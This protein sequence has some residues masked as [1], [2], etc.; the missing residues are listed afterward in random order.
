MEP[1]RFDGR[2]AI[3]TGAGRG[4]GRAHAKLLAERGALVVVNDLGGAPSGDGHDVAPAESV[5]AEV[6]AAGGEAVADASDVSTVDGAAALVARAID[7]YGRV[8]IVVNN[9]GISVSDEFPAAD[10]DHMRRYFDVHVGGTFNVT[11]EA[12]P[13]MVRAGYGRIVNTAS[14]GIYGAVTLIA[15]GT[16]KA[17]IFS[18]TRSLAL[19]GRELGIKVNTVAPVA[20]TRLTGASAEEG[21]EPSDAGL[22]SPRLVSP[23]VAVLCHE[24]C[25]VT[26]E[27]FISGGR[28]QA[29][30]YVAETEGY[31]HPGLDVTPEAVAAN[32]AEVMDPADHMV[33]PDTISWV[34]MH[35]AIVAERS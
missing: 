27:A 11:R 25:P 2:V 1:L 32:W 29:L 15:Y 22:G 3:V 8:D 34:G 26:G 20:A 14:S 30:I 6:R 13:H 4:I 17:G 21:S 31:V 24:S 16:A 19:T 33:P 10:L 12:W 23:L 7:T 28:R 9:A 5:V 18:L 35:Q